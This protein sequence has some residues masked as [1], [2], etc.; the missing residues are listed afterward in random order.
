MRGHVARMGK[1][2]IAFRGLGVKL[3]RK[4]TVG[5]C[6]RRWDDNIKK[7]INEIGWERLYLIHI[8]QG[9]KKWSNLVDTVMNFWV[10]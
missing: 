7:D 1:K 2:T 9:S 5:R 3:K 4:K 6:E 8:A 10:P